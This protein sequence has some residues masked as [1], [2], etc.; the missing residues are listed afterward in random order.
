MANVFT[1]KDQNFH[2]GDTV[3]VQM[4]V[5][6]GDKSRIQTFE[7]LIIKINGQGASKSFTVRKIGANAVGVERILPLGSPNIADIIKKAEGKVRRAK[8]YYLRDRV[9]KRA[10]KVKVKDNRT[11][12]AET[13][14]AKVKA[15]AKPAK[16]ASTKKTKAETGK[17][18][19]AASKKAAAK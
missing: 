19:R 14:T 1:Y 2:T 17:T 8:L 6:E 11:P 18:G 3:A 16:K 12:K 15:D 9:G 5:W 4:N 10:L 7:G 13:K